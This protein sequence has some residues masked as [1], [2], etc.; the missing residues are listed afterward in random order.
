MALHFNK[1]KFFSPND[2]LCQVWLILANWSGEDE[3]V[4]SLQTEEWMDNRQTIR[5]AH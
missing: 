3:N 5:K 1:F 2:T 4:K